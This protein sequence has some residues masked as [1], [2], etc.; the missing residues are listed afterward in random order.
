MAARTKRT[1]HPVNVRFPADV[2]RRLAHFAQ[3]TDSSKSA[4]VIRAVDEYLLWRIPQQED[5]RIALAEVR[6]GKAKMVDNREVIAWLE[7]FI[8]KHD[9]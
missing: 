4:V 8:R 5:L 6:S 9:R 7:G 2:G 1:P 3:L